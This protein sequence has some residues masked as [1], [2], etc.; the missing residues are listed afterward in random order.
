MWYVVR[1]GMCHGVIT[2]DVLQSQSCCEC[3]MDFVPCDRVEEF[4]VVLPSW[5]EGARKETTRS[6]NEDSSFSKNSAS[7]IQEHFFSSN[8]SLGLDC[9][10]WLLR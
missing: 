8:Q 4:Q 10:L 3:E 7:R 5:G 9:L 6:S 1:M 2:M